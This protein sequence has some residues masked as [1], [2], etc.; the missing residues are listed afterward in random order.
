M[1]KVVM[2]T[3]AVAMVAAANTEAANDAAS[4]LQLSG[5]LALNADKSGG[6]DSD[7]QEFGEKCPI[8]NIAM[9][10]ASLSAMKTAMDAPEFCWR[11]HRKSSCHEWEPNHNRPCTAF[12]GCVWAAGRCPAGTEHAGELELCCTYHPCD[13]GFERHGRGCRQKCEGHTPVKCGAA[14]AQSGACV[15]TIATMSLSVVDAVISTVGLFSPASGVMATINVAES[16]TKQALQAGVKKGMK[17]LKTKMSRMVVKGSRARIQAFKDFKKTLKSM[18]SHLKISDFDDLA[19]LTQKKYMFDITVN[20]I[21]RSVNGHGEDDTF[22]FAKFDPTGF[23]NAVKTSADGGS[24]AAQAEGWLS[25]AATMDPSGWLSVAATFAKPKCK[26]ETREQQ[27]FHKHT[28]NQ[29][30]LNRGGVGGSNQY[31]K[32]VGKYNPQACANYV[33]SVEGC[34]RWF[35]YGFKDGWCDC[36]KETS[37]DCVPTTR[38]DAAQ[39]EYAVYEVRGQQPFQKHADMVLCLNRG[40]IGGNNQY[41]KNVGKNNPQ[42]CADYVHHTQGCGRWFDY[43][44]RDGWCDCVKDTSGGCHLTASGNSAAYGY[45]VYTVGAGD[46]YSTLQ[47]PV[48]RQSKGRRLATKGRKDKRQPRRRSQ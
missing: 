16:K 31:S 20:E 42:A 19:C 23:A 30:C 38:G 11:Q 7:G 21:A 25:A 13:E 32:N 17:K 45:G 43:G 26:A 24:G 29:L 9:S 27:P 14:C 3:M 47:V 18:T 40:G 37:G 41:S 35:S 6:Q 2:S 4:M 5:I 28:N 10:Q 8:S 12:Q 36:V 48:D 46:E 22:N 1:V 33:H 39:W 44:T 15:T 34:G